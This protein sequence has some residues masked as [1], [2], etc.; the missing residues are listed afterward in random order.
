MSYLDE[1]PLSQED[2]PRRSEACV[3]VDHADC[4]DGACGCDCH[5]DLDGNLDVDPD[6]EDR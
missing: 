6:M 3:N 5:D 2:A 4:T 1:P